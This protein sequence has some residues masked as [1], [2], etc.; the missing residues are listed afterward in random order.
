MPLSGPPMAHQRPEAQSAED[1]GLF[2]CSLSH[3]HPPLVLFPPPFFS[4]ILS[5][6][7]NSQASIVLFALAGAAL[8]RAMQKV[9]RLDAKLHDLLAQERGKIIPKRPLLCARVCVVCCVLLGVSVLC[10][11]W[12][13]RLLGIT[14]FSG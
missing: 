8:V 3:T 2:L 7:H 12:G 9:Q 5:F 11:Q 6:Y 13:V 10:S 4:S 1:G 14:L